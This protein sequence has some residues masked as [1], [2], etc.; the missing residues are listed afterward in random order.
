V[1]YIKQT[2]PAIAI[3]PQVT[4]PLI[5]VMAEGDLVMIASVTYA[6]DPMKPGQQY[7]STHF[8]LYR[9]ENGKIA[10]HWDHVAKD[11]KAQHFNPNVET[12]KKKP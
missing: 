10:E 4:F 11:P 1:K 2:R 3:P 7:A 5:S 12:I 8:D 9:M 6:D